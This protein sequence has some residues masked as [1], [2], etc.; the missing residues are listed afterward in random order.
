MAPAR[1]TLAEALAERADKINKIAGAFLDADRL[2]Q[3]AMLAYNGSDA[4][5][6]CSAESVIRAVYDAARLGLDLDGTQAA[7]VPFKGAATCMPMYQGLTKLAYEDPTVQALEVRVARIG[8]I[9]KPV[10]GTTPSII[11]EPDVDAT[12]E[13]EARAYYAVAFLRDRAKFDVMWK[14]EIEKV[15]LRS[16]SV[17]KE[18]SSP[19]VD[20]YDEMAKKTV[21][22]RLLKTLPKRPRLVA[23]IDHDNLLEAEDVTSTVISTHATSQARA[24]FGDAVAGALPPPDENALDADGL[25]AQIG[26]EYD[27]LGVPADRRSEDQAVILGRSGG[28]PAATLGEAREVLAVLREMEPAHVE[29][30]DPPPSTEG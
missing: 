8:E 20:F 26:R 19:W 29:D 27:R 7:L 25:R 13:T 6:R 14:W 16:P 28:R 30:E 18:R 17:R 10:Y 5:R 4:L 15:R 11:H 12:E 21:L 22:K 3:L 24:E 9:F 2:I 1:K 23:A